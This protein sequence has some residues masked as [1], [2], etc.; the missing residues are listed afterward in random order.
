MTKTLKS[1]YFRIEINPH[2]NHETKNLEL[3]SDY[4]RIEIQTVN[5]E[6]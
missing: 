3:K 5:C 6:I 1:D 2:F 4:F